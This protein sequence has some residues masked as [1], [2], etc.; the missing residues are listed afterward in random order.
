MTRILPL[1]VVA[2]AS[3]LDAG[4]HRDEGPTSGGGLW[5]LRTG[6]LP[7]DAVPMPPHRIVV[8]VD[9]S[10]GAAAAVRWCASFVRLFGAHV[11]AIHAVA[12]VLAGALP[13]PAAPLPAANEELARLGGALE[14]WCAPLRDAPLPYETRVVEG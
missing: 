7:E 3:H 8:G 5:T 10:P 1:E 6:V 11:V 13:Q 9:G 4:S 2:R 14:D 12:P